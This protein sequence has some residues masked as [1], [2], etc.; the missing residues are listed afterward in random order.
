MALPCNVKNMRTLVDALRSGEFTQAFFTLRE[1]DD[2]DQ[3]ENAKFRHCC[4]GVATELALRDGVEYVPKDQTCGC[5]TDHKNDVWQNSV[6]PG[7]VR[8]W[9]GVQENNPFIGDA[10]AATYNDNDGEDFEQISGRFEDTYLKND[11][12]SLIG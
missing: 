4:L 5:C 7:V 8:D 6:L 11:D 2:A 10:R 9:L 1:S 12:G 3:A